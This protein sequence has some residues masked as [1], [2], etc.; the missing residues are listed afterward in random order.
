MVICFVE[1]YSGGSEDWSELTTRKIE[2]AL[3]IFEQADDEV[4][5]TLAWRLRSGLYGIAGR[6]ADMTDA[7]ERVIEPRRAGR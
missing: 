6:W 2:T 4:G 5:Q 7:A 3:P 1:L